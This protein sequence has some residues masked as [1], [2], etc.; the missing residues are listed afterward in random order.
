[1]LTVFWLCTCSSRAF[2]YWIIASSWLA[3]PEL[4]GRGSAKQQTVLS[5]DWF[6]W[7][8]WETSAKLRNIHTSVHC[9]VSQGMLDFVFTSCPISSWPKSG[10]EAQNYLVD[11]FF[12]RF[13]ELSYQMILHRLEGSQCWWYSISVG[14]ETPGLQFLF[15]WS[16]TFQSN[17][18]SLK[19]S[20]TS[21]FLFIASSDFW[22]VQ[23]P[24]SNIKAKWQFKDSWCWWGC[25]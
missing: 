9:W 23:V 1:M 7:C 8:S 25:F 15:V 11:L 5:E 13:W 2:R 18:I 4:T 22:L 16:G 3:S 10:S 20:I 21:P 17:A 14:S 6:W 12:W 19:D 24:G